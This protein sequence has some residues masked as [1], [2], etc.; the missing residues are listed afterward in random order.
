[1]R[2]R[3][4]LPTA[5]RYWQS[6]FLLFFFASFNTGEYWS[7]LK[8]SFMRKKNAVLFL[9]RMATP[10]IFTPKY[11]KE[12]GGHYTSN[13]HVISRYLCTQV[14]SCKVLVQCQDTMSVRRLMLKLVTCSSQEC[15]SACLKVP[16]FATNM[17]CEASEE[18]SVFPNPLVCFQCLVAQHK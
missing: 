1:M 18:W 5:V 6:C 13:T 12:N 15:C 11:Q 14:M 3:R 8:V 17:W 7:S 2:V 16:Y 4:N 10:V 9:R